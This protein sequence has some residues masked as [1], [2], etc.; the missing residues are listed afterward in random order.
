L[1]QFITKSKKLPRKFTDNV[2]PSDVQLALNMLVHLYLPKNQNN[3]SGL[4][5]S[6]KLIQDKA[7][8][9]GIFVHSNS[10]GKAS[11]FLLS[12][13]REFDFFYYMISIVQ[14]FHLI[15]EFLVSANSSNYPSFFFLTT[16]QVNGTFAKFVIDM[17]STLLLFNAYTDHNSQASPTPWAGRQL[18]RVPELKYGN[19]S[20]SQLFQE[21]QSIL[22]EYCRNLNMS[23]ATK[24]FGKGWS[25]DKLDPIWSSSLR[26]YKQLSGNG[27][28]SSHPSS[29]VNEFGKRVEGMWIHHFVIL[30][31]FHRRFRQ[32]DDVNFLNDNCSS[33]VKEMTKGEMDHYYAKHNK[34]PNFRYLWVH[35]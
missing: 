31:M 26:Y 9:D 3:E 15:Y 34:W 7:A 11:I 27:I 13:F 5:N 8:A 32:H 23:A 10:I 12:F 18:S 25:V 24:F 30:Q 22:I 2:N 16:F 21:N 19:K 4:D 28:V 1:L 33:F 6:M 14:S 29:Y 20:E 35:D 17:L